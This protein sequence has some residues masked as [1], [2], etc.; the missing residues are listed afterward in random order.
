M[1]RFWSTYTAASHRVMFLPGA[2][3]GVL[4]M[5]W[6]LLDMES[7]R[8]G[9]TGL[10]GLPGPVLHTWWMLYGFFPF[11]IFGFL[12]TAAPNWLNGPAIPKPAYVASGV[13]MALGLLPIYA[14]LVLP[15][16]ALHLAGWGVA[17]WALW[18][19]LAGAP[20]QDKFHP[21]IATGAA[22]LGLFGDALFLLWAGWDFPEA[23]RM[24]EAIGIWGF[25]V[26]TFLTV[27]HRMIPWFTSRIV[28]NYVMV[29]PYG[30]LWGL[31]AGCLV[32][33]TLEVMERRELLWLVDLP[34]TIVVF[35]FA[36]RWGVARGARQVRLLSMLHIAF[37][38]LGLALLL[39]TGDSL[40]R[41]AGLP[42]N[43]GHA[44]LHALGIGF[45]TS[46]LIGMASRVSLGHS[47]RKL[48]ADAT[49]WGL[50][51]LV[52]AVA[53]LRLLPELLPGLPAG[54]PQLLI[55]LAGAMWLLAFGVWAG[56]YAPMT[57]RP[58]VDG[59]P[60]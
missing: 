29:R 51:W 39:H 12:F 31:L 16:L 9:G 2:L 14:G 49:T 13:L 27:C 20:P 45:F 34:M 25:L 35:W 26:P 6:W 52:Q 11:F 50:F 40:A 38:W 55:P 10:G 36:T 59:K 41:Y 7:R 21:A 22:T 33:G 28:P 46:M 53:L 1:S 23:L 44:P 48:E 56:K 18:R 60:G 43:A 37:L 4:V 15:G 54:L 57:W 19:T 17:V 42:W 8:T 5:L 58:R 30:P 47:G 24:A 32:H 3:Q